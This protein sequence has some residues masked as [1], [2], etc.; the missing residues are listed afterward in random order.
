MISSTLIGT[1]LLGAIPNDFYKLEVRVFLEGQFSAS[2]L[3]L[4]ENTTDSFWQ[5]RLIVVRMGMFQFHGRIKKKG[6]G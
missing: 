2:T 4:F 1:K 5:T 3:T 6:N